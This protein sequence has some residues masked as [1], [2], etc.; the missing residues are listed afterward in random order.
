MFFRTIVLGCYDCRM[1]KTLSLGPLNI[2][3][4]GWIGVWLMNNFMD[5]LMGTLLDNLM[6]V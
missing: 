5:K 2:L 3:I 1:L 4:S 6:N